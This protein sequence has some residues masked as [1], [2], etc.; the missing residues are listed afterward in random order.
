M[1]IPRDFLMDDQVVIPAIHTG[2]A[3]CGC[4][5]FIVIFSV[6]KPPAKPVE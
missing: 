4:A 3:K 1:T 2:T 5:F 6:K